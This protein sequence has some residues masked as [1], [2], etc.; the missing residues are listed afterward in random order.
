MPDFRIF[1]AGIS[2]HR[3]RVYGA[4]V[5]VR[6]RDPAHGRTGH[7]RVASLLQLCPSVFSESRVFALRVRQGRDAVHRR[8]VLPLQES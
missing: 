5:S 3:T 4:P 8:S 1:A 2:F 7:V 6:I